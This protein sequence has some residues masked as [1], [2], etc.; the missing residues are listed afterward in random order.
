[1]VIV[2]LKQELRLYWKITRNMKE[3]G[4][5]DRISNKEKVDR[6]GPTAQDTMAG[7]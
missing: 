2:R 5:L 3:N 4:S 7:G 6:Y 1:M